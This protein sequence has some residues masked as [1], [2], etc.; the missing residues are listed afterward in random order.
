MDISVYLIELLRLH[1]CVIVPDLGGFVTNYRPAEMDL[2]SNSFSPP[3]KEIIFSSKLDNNDGLL[4]NHISET[5]GVGY[6]EARLIVSEFVDELK[7]K[8]ENGEKVELPMVGSL[9]YD[10]N[11]RLIFEPEIQENLLLDAFG[12]EGFQFPQIKHYE[13]LIS[14]RPYVNKEA[15]RP[16]FSKRRVKSLVI[17][18]PILLALLIIPATRSS[19]KNY[20][21]L[22]NQSSGTAAIELNQPLLSNVT[23][24]V[25]PKE[26]NPVANANSNLASV[27]KTE[28]AI[29]EK[30]DI[31]PAVVNDPL[32][33]K[34]HVIGG[35]FKMKEN[36]DKLL[37]RLRAEGFKSK[38]N[39]FSN[40]NFMVTV[41][42]Y[43]D[44]NEAQLALNTLRELEPQAGYWLLVK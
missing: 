1:D 6:L 31:A 30:K 4:V 10:R 13:A 44:R 18:I 12:L 41:Q 7:S 42:S 5:E 3:M 21:F 32:Q 9:Q 20:N 36:A 15:V 27:A 8:L 35:C 2:A 23:P 28:T 11:E 39:Q 17:G 14:K 25:A 29:A 26:I 16:V 33:E 34:Y 38:V 19:W 24:A 22:N 40:G 43:V 37:E